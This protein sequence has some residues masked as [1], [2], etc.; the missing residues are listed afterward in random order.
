MNEVLSDILVPCWLTQ[1][2]FAYPCHNN[3]LA[4]ISRCLVGSSVKALQCKLLLLLV[5][6]LHFGSQ[7]CRSP[8]R[9]QQLWKKCVC[10]IRGWNIFRNG[11]TI[12]E[13]EPFHH[14]V[15]FPKGY[16]ED[17]FNRPQV[18]LSLPGYRV[19]MSNS[20]RADLFSVSGNCHLSWSIS[21]SMNELD[22]TASVIWHLQ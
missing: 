9:S 6:V 7:W 2:L 5:P 8:D 17:F 10:V 13:G 14:F 16:S 19:W 1:G 20:C 12:F 4:H 22:M 18:E 15:G 21:Q 3:V 11:A